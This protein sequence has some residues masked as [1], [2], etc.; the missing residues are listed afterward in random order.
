M[1]QYLRDESI[2]NLSLSEDALRKINDDLVEIS[3]QINESLKKQFKDEELTRKLLIS[4]YI[5]RFDGR[6]F[7][8]FEFE[9]IMRYF[10]DAKKVERFIFIIDSIGS[11][12]RIAGKSIDLNFDPLDINKCQLVVQDDDANWVDAVFCKLK[13]R[14]NKYKNRNFIIQ[15]RWI[16]FVVQLLGVII[17]FV[18]SLWVAIKIS[19]KL[20]IDSPLAFT[21]VI[22]FLLFSN[23]WTLLYEG[24]L[25]TLNYF[26]PNI[27]FKKRDGFHW[28]FKALISSVFVS[29]ILLILSRLL[30]YIGSFIKGI[31]K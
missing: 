3:K 27:S 30:L 14:L 11:I 22:A 23:T 8:L 10:Q 12:N 31:L 5:I 19:P 16:P 21:F 17:G 1:S 9:K 29:I 2:R 13:E 26:W 7:R 24:I 25:R 18:I 6:G 15:N 28:L 20:L 4:S